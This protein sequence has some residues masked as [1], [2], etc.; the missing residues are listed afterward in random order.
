[1]FWVN[2]FGCG[3]EMVRMSSASPSPTIFFAGHMLIFFLLIRFI[4]VLPLV[5]RFFIFHLFS[6]HVY[7]SLLYRVSETPP[8][9]FLSL[10]KQREMRSCWLAARSATIT[11]SAS[12]ERVSVSFRFCSRQGPF[13]L[14]F[15]YFSS[16]SNILNTPSYVY[17][18][19]NTCGYSSMS[20]GK[21]VSHDV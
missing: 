1:M 4:V 11:G 21:V 15:R 17:V 16:R 10:R 18:A 20:G 3:S 6:R 13:A 5:V 2:V 14:E 7:I 19:P 9:Y 8:V 12:P